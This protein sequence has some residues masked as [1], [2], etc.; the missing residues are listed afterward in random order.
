MRGADRSKWACSRS[1]HL[2]DAR[3]RKWTKHARH[4]K[5]WGAALRWIREFANF[6]KAMCS[7]NAVSYDAVKMRA[8]DE[9]CCLFLTQVAEQHKG[10]SRVVAARRALSRQR[11]REKGSS[12]NGVEDISLLIDGVRRSQPRTK[13][14]VESLDINDVTAMARAL[15]ASSQWQD[16]QLGVLI[17]TGFLTIMRYGELQRVYRRGVR[18]V[19]KSG[20]EVSLSQLRSPSSV[21]LDLVRGLLIHVPWRKA[22]QMVDA[23]IPMSCLTTIGR[24]LKHEQSLRDLRSESSYLFPSVQRSR[25]HPPHPRNYFGATQFRNSLR[26]A[27]RDICGMSMQESKVYGGHSLRVGGSNFMRRLGI[28]PDIH[29]SLG[30]WA[31]LKSA[32]DYM[33]LSPAEQFSLTRSLAVQQVRH[34]AIEDAGIAQ[35]VIPRLQ[36]LAIGG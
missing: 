12:L 29:R 7:A 31:V 35:D 11:I 17:T 24:L 8:D 34:S 13:F 28:D 19:F 30:G 15:S 4:H 2:R 36:R 3:V 22:K 21:D 18:V 10:I 9:L 25:G 32:R 6:A 20:R 5:S 33:Q 1:R 27:L 16:R 26:K 23:W 14:Q